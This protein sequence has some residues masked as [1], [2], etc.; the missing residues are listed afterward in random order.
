[1]L[2]A[3]HLFSFGVFCFFLW[4]IGDSFVNSMVEKV[5]ESLKVI[6]EQVGY[7]IYYHRN[8]KTLLTE[9]EKLGIIKK[10]VEHSVLEA[11]N[12]GKRIGDG[13]YSWLK[14]V[15]R[16]NEEVKMLE[17]EATLNKSWLNG[18]CPDLISRYSLS[19]EA[20]KKTQDVIEL[21]R[22]NT[23]YILADFESR[24][25][26]MVE[27]MAAPKDDSI[28][29]IGM[30][31][32]GGVGKTTKSWQ[33]SR[34]TKG[35]EALMFGDDQQCKEGATKGT[36][37]SASIAPTW[38]YDVFLSTF[39]GKDT[40]NN[41]TDR[42]YRALVRGG[43]RTFRDVNQLRKGDEAISSYLLEGIER[44]RVSVLVF[45]ENYADST[46]CLDELVKILECKTKVGQTVLPVFYDVSPSDVRKQMGSFGEAFSKLKERFKWE[47]D[48]GG[49]VER[50]R[51]ALTEAAT[52]SGWDLHDA[53]KGHESKFIQQIVEEIS[54]KLN[55]KYF[56]IATYPVGIDSKAEHLNGLLKIDSNVVLTIGICGISGIGKTTIAKA[57]YNLA[58]LKFDGSS[59][60]HDV[61][62]AAKRPD[63]LVQLQKQLL[64]DILLKEKVEIRSVDIGIN[65]IKYKLCH[66]RVLLVLDD[67]DH[68]DQLNALVGEHNWFGLG[69]RIIITTINEDLL[70]VLQ[71]DEMYSVPELRRDE[72]LQLFS[73]HAFQQDHPIE[74]YNEISNDIVGYA[75]GLPL[76]LEVL[77]RSL[78][79][80]ASMALWIHALENLKNTPND[81]ILNILRISFDGL[82]DD[83]QKNVFLDIAC[84]FIGMDKDY[85]LRILN[86]CGFSSEAAIH[87]LTER[88][89]LTIDKNNKLK[90]HD[91]LRDMGREI[92]LEES[93]NNPGERSRLWFHE[94][95]N[96]V[97]TKHSGTG[98]VEGIVLDFLI[99]KDLHF[100]AEAFAKMHKLRLL[101]LDSVDLTGDY[102]HISGE[103]RWLCWHRFPLKFIPTRFHLENLVALD[104]C[105]SSLTQIWKETRVLYKLKFLNVSHSHC[106]MKTPDFKGLPSLEKLLLEDCISLVEVHPSIGNLSKLVFLN[107][108]DC[109]NLVNLPR[110]IYTLTSLENLD[111]SGCSNISLSESLGRSS[112]SIPRGL[113][114]SLSNCMYLTELCLRDCN[115][116]DAIP[117]DIGSL[118]TLKILD[119]RGNNF[120]CLPDTMTR[121]S[122]L[123]TLLLST[124]TRL[125][126]LPELPE[127]LSCL[128]ADNCWSL[129]RL[130][131]VSNS[132]TRP[133]FMLGSCCS[134]VEIQVLD[135]LE[136][137][138][139]LEMGHCNKLAHT[140]RKTGF[141]QELFERCMSGYLLPATDIPGW[142]S[143][144]S[145]GSSI[146]FVVPHHVII[147]GLTLGILYSSNTAFTGIYSYFEVV[148]TDKTKSL[149]WTP[150]INVE[151]PLTRE[152]HLLVG[153]IPHSSL[154][155]QLEGGD[156]LEVSIGEDS[157]VVK[158][159][160]IRWVYEQG[161]KV[162]CSNDQQA[163][164]QYTSPLYGH[165]AVAP[166]D[167]RYGDGY[168]Q[169]LEAGPSRDAASSSSATLCYS[170]P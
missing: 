131:D 145:L 53:A 23:R 18:W 169:G 142:F 10:D 60:L 1:M 160:G 70:K 128:L 39:R 148:V 95:V 135:K 44:S 65:L 117:S 124:C 93:P 22:D 125:Q 121:L 80:E 137:L 25:K 6:F 155:N 101:H 118:S 130:P 34:M 141:L 76:A 37:D 98:E 102:E 168:V 96:E 32:L 150:P 12:N 46:W 42:L 138:D 75:G 110:S 67:V 158:K 139:A 97:L 19:W 134:L 13:V 30:C 104:M 71:V 122:K 24:R 17:D 144:Q 162:P 9:I 49:R 157:L 156:E 29:A 43:I 112:Y 127:N 63:G 47:I 88:H 81:D 153:F 163:V 54:I 149:K 89:L 62:K 40:R 143:Y 28:N 74:D 57:V 106:L 91:L 4:K 64:Y 8:M 132:Q 45:S 3:V 92:I 114:T 166:E 90:M 26:V 2:F 68:L 133:S 107:L 16:I 105:Y 164:I 56:S 140:F 27:I 21:Q 115:L 55:H 5:R 152:P 38:N 146:A 126:L 108:K 113:P 147:Q 109:K 61:R 151:I 73:W 103:L 14:T 100:S 120:I 165:V 35:T 159:C 94:D 154:G 116:V 111:L 82:N 129:E 7:L 99:V 123:R 41:F 79:N 85:V 11:Q 84:Y 36:A 136:S 161:V 31:G 78:S 52:L 77:G 20:K 48:G 50:W 72:S 86:D 170:T 119:L 69:S 58:F 83:G 33:L 87:V 66:K 15:D 167:D 59:F 51:A